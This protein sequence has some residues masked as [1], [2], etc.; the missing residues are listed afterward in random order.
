VNS[1]GVLDTISNF[2][3]VPEKTWEIKVVVAAVVAAV[4]VVTA[5]IGECAL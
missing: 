3:L 2:V 4:V 5:T 1:D